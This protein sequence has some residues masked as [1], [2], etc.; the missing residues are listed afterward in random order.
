MT[1]SVRLSKWG[2]SVGVRLPKY[3]VDALGLKPGSAV[4]VSL[5]NDRIVLYPAHKYCLND[6]VSKITEE[7]RHVE[8]DWGND[9]GN[10]WW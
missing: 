1:S 9:E 4:N 2:N 3:V 10:E 5:E 8:T 7:N 6:L